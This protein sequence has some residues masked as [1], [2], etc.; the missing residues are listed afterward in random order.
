MGEETGARHRH[1][2][3]VETKAVDNGQMLDVDIGQARAISADGT[4]DLLAKHNQLERGL[5]SRHIQFIALGGAI[6]TG[7][8]VGSG[9][10]LQLVGPAPLFMGY[11]SMMLL[12]WNIMNVLGEMSTFLPLKGISIPYFVDRFVEPS[13]A[14]ATGWNYWYAYAML[15]GAEAVAGSILLDYWQTAVPSAVWITI[16]LAVTLGLNIFAVGIFGEAEFWFASIKFIT[17]MGLI[18]TSLVIML[19]GAPNNDRLGFRYWYDPGAIKPYLAEGNTGNFIAYWAAFIRAG[20]AFITSPEL[21]ALAAGETMAPRRNIPKAARRFI[22]RLAIF[23]GLGSLMVG[24][25]TP[26]N[27]DRLLS[28]QSN[29][30][31]SPWV[32]GIQRAGIVGLDHVVNAAVLTSAWSAGNAFLYSGSRVMYSLALNGQAPAVF[33]RTSKAGVPYMAVLATW[34]VGLLAY[35]NV[36]TN[37][38]KVFDWFW[39]ICTISGFIAWIVIMITYIRFHAALKFRGLLHTLPFKTRFQPYGSYFTL[40]ILVL[41]TLTSGFDIFPPSKWDV[42]SF[43]AAYVTLPIF[44]V[45]YLGHKMVY[46]TPLARKI[47]DIDVVTGVKEMEELAASDVEPVPKNMLQRIWF[48]IA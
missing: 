1:S 12:V 37:S 35:L 40:F 32:I 33:K 5:K 18:L 11:L 25:I 3:D 46:R 13:L 23:Y 15:V 42:E 38:A 17:I 9:R 22:W 2:G 8:F 43:I 30:S 41:L 24:V 47:E 39:A 48:W 28:P 45:L 36:S 27:D 16:I 6:G 14:F 20:F 19:G 10:I 26:S 4:P 44:L 29:A 31:S 7:L 34:S 21:I